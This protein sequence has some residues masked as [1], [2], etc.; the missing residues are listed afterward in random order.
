MNGYIFRRW[1][2]FKRKKTDKPISMGSLEIFVKQDFHWEYDVQIE[3]GSMGGTYFIFNNTHIFSWL[4]IIR[5]AVKPNL[6]LS[7][8]L[9]WVMSLWFD[10]NQCFLR[11]DC[12]WLINGK[13]GEE[14]EKW[15]AMNSVL[16]QQCV[17]YCYGYSILLVKSHVVLFTVYQ[18]SLLIS[19]EWKRQRENALNHIGQ[20]WHIHMT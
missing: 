9:G 6:I 12:R 10:F 2:Q 14:R 4:H 5:F 20:W 17:L 15:N 13:T 7:A 18:D 8:N 1:I 11:F 3:D 16:H 19:Y